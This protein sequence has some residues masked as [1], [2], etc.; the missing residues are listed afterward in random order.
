YRDGLMVEDWNR[1]HP[2]KPQRRSYVSELLDGKT[3]P[4]IISTDYVNAY[5]EQIRH[6]IPQPVTILG[7]DGFG[8][9]DTREVLRRFFKV[10][11]YH[12]AVATLKAL[13][14]EGTL[15]VKKVTQAIKKYGIDPDAP[16]PITC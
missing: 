5:V 14:D 11:R 8:R 2:G 10:D 7:T 6:L 13:A 4:V 16:H 3:G 12:I 1:A 9:S 15:P